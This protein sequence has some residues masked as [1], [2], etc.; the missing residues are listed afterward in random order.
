MEN[1]IIKAASC[2]KSPFDSIRRTDSQGREYWL[3]RELQ[4][5]LGYTKWDKFKQVIELASENVETVGLEPSVEIFP[6]EVKST[7]K[8]LLDYRLSRLACYHV[9]LCC[10][11]R[12]NEQVKLAKHYFAVKARQAEV[13]Q[14]LSPA[15]LLIA[16]GQAML[17]IEKEQ[18]RLQAKQAELEAKLALEAQRTAELE[19]LVH[20]HNGEIDRI[21][22]P[23]G[24]YFSVMGYARNKGL[25]MP[26]ELAQAIGKKCAK[27]CRDNDIL[28]SKLTDPRW[29]T[30]GSYPEDVIANFV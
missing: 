5:I 6:V 11:S 4:K 25:K 2:G 18:S 14:Q 9:A 24:H 28:V 29:G 1:T 10:D 3:A 12:A 15:E 16:Q 17:A 8:P 27:Y 20:Q 7:T 13:S 30:V 23:N 22:N 26:K 21:F 19:Q